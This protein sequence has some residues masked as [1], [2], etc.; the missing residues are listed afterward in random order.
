LSLLQKVRNLFHKPKLKQEAP[1]SVAEIDDRVGGTR[2]KR[3]GIKD[4]LRRYEQGAISQPT[5]V[6]ELQKM[7]R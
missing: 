1:V 6:E 7:M 2:S 3:A 5:A 4:I